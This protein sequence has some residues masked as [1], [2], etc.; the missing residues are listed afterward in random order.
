[1]ILA[2]AAQAPVVLVV[3]SVVFVPGVVA[4]ATVG[5]RG[6]ALLAAAPL[7]SV[8][9]T[10]IVALVY[11]AVGIPWSVSGWVWGMLVLVIAAGAVGWVLRGKYREPRSGPSWAVPTALMTGAV[12][13][14][15]R[16]VDYIAD[17]DAISQTN[18]AVF[19]MNAVRFI[20]ENTD[21][22]SLHV[23][24]MI[25]GNGFYPAAWH[26]IVS[27]IVLL[28]G[29]SIPVAANALT[30]VIGTMVWSIGIAWLT[31]VL[32]SSDVVAGV[33]AIL[34]GAL[35]TFPLLMFQWGVLFPNA[36]SIA[37]LPA[38]VAL[39]ISLR[40]W[41]DLALRWRPIVRSVVFLFVALAALVFSQPAALLPWAAILALW[42]T[43]QLMTTSGVSR[44]LRGALIAAMWAGLAVLW[45]TLS[46]QTSGSHWPPFRGK[47]EALLDVILNGQL[48]IPFA[49]G[50]SM[51][52]V[53][54]LVVAW[55][56]VRMRWF[57][58]AWLLV[59]GLYLLV[60]AVGAPLIRVNV[61]GAWYADP[62]RIAALA[63]LV[64]I[65]L[66]AL[67][68][69]TLVGL[70]VRLARRGEGG[71]ERPEAIATLLS[72]V[73]FMVVLVLVR[74]VAM[75]SF[76]EATFDEESRYAADA[77]SFLSPDERALLE[78]LDEYV[79]PGARVLSNP[80]TGA[81][82]G[83]LFS[84]V[85]VFPRTWS[86]PRSEAWAVLAASLRDASTDPAVCEALAAYSDPEY[87]LD[88]GIGDVTPGRYESE[89]MTDFAGRPGFE[90][91]AEVGDA[92]L[93]RITACAR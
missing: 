25:G 2:W 70:V 93:W 90:K 67:G 59:S 86:T 71:S 50:V 7:F 19:H 1:M 8:A 51:F 15:W 28:T 14:I 49:I 41:E 54:G 57:V 32:T 12:I 37:I 80:S 48:R 74:P 58:F 31:R 84:G 82:F 78:S 64:V 62:Y 24:G 53:V 6:L 89:G 68:L 42:A 85:D 16:L 35:Q 21:A 17:P 33:A 45:L 87:V 73:V 47:L 36:L 83:Y 39:V 44:Y 40:P 13:G 76:I 9:A 30:I 3:A 61:L 34:S 26:A 66:A 43:A 4:L 52:M 69:H 79:E 22:S 11:G 91:V 23:S 88:F 92:S 38:A 81:G 46:R 29:T 65:P 5:L 75:P 60:A 63:P 10:S 72:A 55:R 18:D 77:D 20:L 27:L 56:A